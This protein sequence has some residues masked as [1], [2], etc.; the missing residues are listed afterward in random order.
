[1]TSRKSG[2]N[3]DGTFGP[4]N[5]GKPRGARHKATQAALALLDGEAGALT[6]KAVQMAL[7]GD[8]TALRLCLERIAPLRRDA[9]VEFAL[10]KMVSARDAAQAAAAVLDAVAAGD[11]TPTEGA[12]IMGLVETYRRTLETSELE[13]RVAA[14]EK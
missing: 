4:G 2:R 9:P 7:A 5:P 11:L 6:R 1:M 13:A 12:H 8:T 3:S 14:L 10:P